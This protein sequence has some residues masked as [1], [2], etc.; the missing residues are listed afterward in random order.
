MGAGKVGAHTAGDGRVVF[1]P[2]ENVADPILVTDDH[3]KIIL[4][5]EQAERLFEL[6]DSTPSR[7]QQQAVRGNDTYFTT[8]IS[9]FLLSTERYTQ[10]R[11]T[12]TRTSLIASRS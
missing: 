11:M 3:S 7:R 12:L 6:H 10:A 9:D 8:F 5:N 1:R 4:M 2:V